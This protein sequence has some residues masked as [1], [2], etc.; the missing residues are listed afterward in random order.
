MGKRKSITERIASSKI[1]KAGMSIALALSVCASVPASALAAEQVKVTV[2]GDIPYAGYFTTNMWADGEI[3]YCA[4]PAAST[5][6]PGTYVKTAEDGNLAAAMW[7]SYGAP[8]FDKSMFPASWYDGS[9]WT[10]DKYHAASHVLLVYCFRHFSRSGRA[11]YLPFQIWDK[12][13]VE[14]GGR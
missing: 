9:G 7:F 4:D 14:G 8:G 1:V 10:D 6:A 12:G 3:A 11:L 2:G 13:R 5:P